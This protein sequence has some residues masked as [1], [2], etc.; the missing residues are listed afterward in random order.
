M[1]CTLYNSTF[2]KS[3]FTKIRKKTDTYT[4]KLARVFLEKDYS[5][6]EASLAV[7]NDTSYH[8]TCKRL[9]NN[10]K[11]VRHVILVGIGGSSLC[12]EAVYHAL[13]T[14]QSPSLTVVDDLDV[15]THAHIAT[16]LKK[17][18]P[19]H[20]AL[21]ITSKSGSTTET[22][23]HAS[24][25]MEL[26]HHAYG[27]SYTKRIIVIGDADS[28]LTVYAKKEKM[29]TCII[30]KNIGGRYSV[31][32]AVGIVPLT[33][34]GIDV[35]KFLHG[36]KDA[37]NEHTLQLSAQN[38]TCI[39]IHAENGVHTVNFFTFDNRLQKVGMWYRQLLG[40]SLGKKTTRK[41]KI[42]THQLHPTVSTSV[43]AHSVVQLYVG[44][45]RDIYT[46]FYTTHV[47]ED[48]VIGNTS[49]IT[50]LAP[51]LSEKKFSDV[52]DAMSM[53]IMRAYDDAQ[54]AYMHTSIDVH[55]PYEIGKLLASL[56]VEVLCLGNIFDVNPF[57]Q[58]N[59]ENYKKHMQTALTTL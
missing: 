56:I 18:R 26:F 46:R 3:H 12:V 53:G 13:K 4:Q 34:L 23:A 52:S 16:L 40:E 51:Q 57:D 29:H 58:P 33:L 45:Y 44:G 9:C 47:T 28:M 25:I 35:S 59:V 8:R 54:L 10:F 50:L 48:A 2:P 1:Q 22:I 38:A 20:I 24:V 30:P 37:C 14:T 19:E 42:F 15:S 41:N 36:A 5:V 27:S 7:I 49:F 17:T 6:P 43:D 21:I 31:F 39:A 11:E 32:T 55:S